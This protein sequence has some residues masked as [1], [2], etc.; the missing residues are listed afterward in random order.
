MTAETS[1]VG[2]AAA[3]AIGLTGLGAAMAQGRV[4]AAALD[5]GARNPAAARAL[6]ATMILGLGMIESVLVVVLV[7]LMTKM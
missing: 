1:I 5:G 4:I 7:F 3:L 2:S 6:R